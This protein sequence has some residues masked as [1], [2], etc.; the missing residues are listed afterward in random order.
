MK[1]IKFLIIILCFLSFS[2]SYGNTLGTVKKRGYIACGVNTGLPGF[3]SSD[4]K[5]KWKGLDVDICRAVSAAVFGKPNQ[6]KFIPLTTQQRFTA[7][8]S[9]EVDVL[10]RNTTWN[11]QRDTAQGLNFA[12]VTYYDGQGFML[13]KSAK[14]KTLKKLNGATICVSQGTTTELGLAD[15]FKSHKMKFKPLVFESRDEM[16][17]A[18][19]KKRCDVVT[20]DASSLAG[21]R[22]KLQNPK[23]YVILKKIISKEPLAPVVR[24]GDDQWFDV[25]KWTVFALIAAEE[26]GITSKNVSSMKRSRNPDVKRFLGVIKGNGKALGLNERWAYHV[27][28]HVGNYGEIFERNLG[29]KTK[30]NIKRGLNNL[31]TKGGLHYSPP[32]R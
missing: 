13:R 11:L 8:Q 6:L 27:V 7:L 10:S 2:V 17:H 29:S 32:V 4:S 22:T 25:V 28:K 26:M 16:V 18:F 30:L 15:Y 20:A 14:I 21:D 5:G 24:H 9:G 3:S 19:V 1:T 12:P 23:Q 31:W